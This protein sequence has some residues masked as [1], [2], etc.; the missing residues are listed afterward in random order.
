M[1]YIAYQSAV[2]SIRAAC[3]LDYLWDLAPFFRSFANDFYGTEGLA[4]P[5][6]MSLAGQP[7]GGWGA[8]FAFANHERLECAPVLPALALHHGRR[9][10]AQSR[11]SL[12]SGVGQ[13]M[14]GLL[15]PD[16]DGVLKLLRSSSPEIYGNTYLEPN[17][18]YDL[19]CLRML[20]L[21]LEEMADAPGKPADAHAGKSCRRSPGRLPRRGRWRIAAGPQRPL[22]ES[23]RHPANLMAIYPFNLITV[24]GS[25]TDRQ[26]IQTTLARPEWHN[27][28]HFEWCGYTWAWMSCLH[29]RVGDGEAALR[30][31]ECSKRLIFPEMASM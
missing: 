5:G 14:A 28:T 27:K 26:R 31:L 10:S 22:R 20:F 6:V 29:S 2:S 11:V 25:E 12:V 8:L 9:L 1:T 21:S 15:K 7:L 17:T 24:E 16:P 3:Y 13:C 23:H 30:H 19:M 4:T 18:N